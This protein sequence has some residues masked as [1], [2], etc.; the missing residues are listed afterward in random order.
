MEWKDI[1]IL[2]LGWSLGLLS[3]LI[4]NMI[5]DKIKMKELKQCIFLELDELRI[6][7]AILRYQLESKY[8]KLSIEL[9]DYLIPIFENSKG[10]NSTEN[11][12][13]ALKKFKTLSEEE[14][15]QIIENYKVPGSLSIKKLDIPFLKSKIE[16]LGVFDTDLQRQLL[17]INYML[18]LY[19]RQ[20]EENRYYYKM[21]FDGNISDENHIIVSESLNQSYNELTLRVRVLMK[22]IDSFMEVLNNKR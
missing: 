6:L 22:C 11:T 1:I 10:M 15:N 21:T 16:E 13:K 4:T 7:L 20:V 3:P 5:N 17:N 8:N 9:I 2:L 18:D 14:F 12:L 19:N